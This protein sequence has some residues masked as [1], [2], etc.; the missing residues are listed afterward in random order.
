M[1]CFLYSPHLQKSFDASSV[2]CNSLIGRLCILSKHEDFLC[3]IKKS[4]VD[5]CISDAPDQVERLFVADASLSV[6]NYTVSIFA[7]FA[8]LLC[9]DNKSVLEKDMD[10]LKQRISAI[11]D[12]NSSEYLFS[13]EKLEFLSYA[14]ENIS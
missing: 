3:T 10:A 12:K 13:V 14:L 9:L 5:I 4:I 6:C 8:Y 2:E 7:D 11:G 1:Q